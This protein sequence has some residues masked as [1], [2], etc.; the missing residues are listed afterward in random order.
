MP[1][2]PHPLSGPIQ[3]HFATVLDA[4]KGGD[5]HAG[6]QLVLLVY[7]ELKHVAASLLRQEQGRRTAPLTLQPTA[8]VHEAYVRLIGSGAPSYEGRQ[9][10]FNAAARAMRNILIDRARSARVG[11]R[12]PELDSIILDAAGST[13]GGQSTP[14]G[15]EQLLALEGALSRLAER[16][17]RQHEVVM[18]RYFA[19]LSIAQTAEVMS[20][21]PATV[22]NEWSFARAWLLHELERA[23]ESDGAGGDAQ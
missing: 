5:A 13:G 4:A 12:S 14:I 1:Q 17:D 2:G 15:G 18:L 7:A 11:K 22:K 10:F 6:D 21:S 9:H 3:H 16:D 23:A 8:L 20:L 19:G